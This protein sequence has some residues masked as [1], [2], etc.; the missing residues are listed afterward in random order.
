MHWSIN[1]CLVGDFRSNWTEIFRH[2]S[3]LP[4]AYNLS[5]ETD[6]FRF[7]QWDA[8]RKYKK[9]SIYLYE[10]REECYKETWS[11]NLRITYFK[12]S[13]QKKA[14]NNW[15]MGFLCESYFK[16]LVY[17]NEIILFLVWKNNMFLFKLPFNNALAGKFYNYLTIYRTLCRII[18]FTPL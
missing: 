13:T 5:L 1:R 15:V 2:L 3:L 18:H 8:N 4:R 10:L 16:M 11:N 12:R 14:S 7:K 9:M 6:R 17:N